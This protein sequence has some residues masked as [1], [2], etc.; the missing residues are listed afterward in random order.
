MK[1]LVCRPADDPEHWTEVEARDPER[2]VTTHAEGLCGRDPGY[3]EVF[4]G[5]DDLLVKVAGGEPKRFEVT[6]EA[7]PHFSARAK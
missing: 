6:V 3:Y 5:G 4:T 1:H 7:V 2:A